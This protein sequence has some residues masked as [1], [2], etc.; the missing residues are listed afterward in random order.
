MLTSLSS[1]GAKTVHRLR[2]SCMPSVSC[3]GKVFRWNTDLDPES[4]RAELLVKF[5]EEPLS[6]NMW[7][8]HGIHHPSGIGVV[9]HC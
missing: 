1:R 8:W 6:K 4:V 2:R 7:S 9:R 3:G 5:F